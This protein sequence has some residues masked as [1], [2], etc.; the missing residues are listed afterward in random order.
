MK[1]YARNTEIGLIPLYD[2]DS[3][4]K[5]K[6]KLNEDYE[7]EIKKAR[8]ILFHKKYFALIK[9]VW[10][11]LPESFDK[12][13]PHPDN[14]RKAVQ[15]MAGFSNTFYLLDGTQIIESKSIAFEN[16]DELEFWEL[17]NKVLDVIIKYILP[18]T[19]KEEIEQE[20]FNFL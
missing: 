10:L 6:L 20:I 7:I 5:G 4:E 19:T 14:F 13:Y 11:N 18:L 17:Y 15:I 9:L 1:L 12:L 3:F 2:S 8:N 16:M